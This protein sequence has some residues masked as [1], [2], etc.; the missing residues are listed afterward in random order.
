MRR[1][2]AALVAL[3]ASLV[4]YA[5]VL[6][7]FPATGDQD[8]ALHAL[9]ARFPDPVRVLGIWA[10]PLF[11][12]PYLLPARFGY[13]AMRLFTVLI[14]IAT[15]WATYL[16]ARRIGVRRAWVAIPLVL[17]QPALLQVGTD[18]MTEPIFA[19]TLALGLLAF[20]YDRLLLAA[21][22]WS[23]LP[24]ARPEGPFILALFA[25]LWLPRALH[26]RRHIAA[27]L[28]LGLGMAVWLLACLAV[29]GSVGY[30]ITLPWGTGSPM[31]GPVTYYM[32]RW[33][34]IIGLGVLPLWLVGLWPSWR[35]PVA[36]LSVLIVAAVFV[37]HTVLFTAGLMGSLGFDRYLAPLAAPVAL[38]AA[39]G[40]DALG[41][42]A[43]RAVLAP[44]LGLLLALEGVHALVAFDSNAINHTA[45]ATL[46]AT[47][48][49]RSQPGVAGR[50]LLSADAFGY[51]F[52]DDDWGLNRLPVGVPE[53]AAA[54]IARLPA[55]TVVLWDDLTGDWWYHLSVEDFTA[56]GYQLLWERRLTVGSPLAPLYQR[57]AN[58]R[59][60][61]LY[62]WMGS[63]PTRE[64][65]EAVLV[66]DGA[67]VVSGS[68]A[69][70]LT[71]RP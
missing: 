2:A 64:M 43:P 59:L 42:I 33:P 25:A 15:A 36:R 49:A 28:L 31:H 45:R 20:A 35:T 51:V 55:G 29:T 69:A 57:V 48:E 27:I 38:V 63:I 39:V 4:P 18:T 44:V 8:A 60:R 50:P 7:L 70:P 1:H 19:L 26:D 62:A 12:V 6:A 68:Q 5:G 3:G 61:R 30:A 32:V 54:E 67:H 10:R 46:M 9:F 66:K 40:A 22:L 65:R 14:C 53:A 16:I 21:A 34:H 23:F 17:L 37:V 52:L 13:V 71:P 41:R 58:S 24:L 47:R 56:R 11:A